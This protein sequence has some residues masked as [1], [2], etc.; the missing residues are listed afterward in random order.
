MSNKK[1][2]SIGWPPISRQPLFNGKTKNIGRLTNQFCHS[3]FFSL[4]GTHLL[5]RFA[6]HRHDL[7]AH[8]MGPLAMLRGGG[9][10]HNRK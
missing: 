3:N 5:A 7:S 6:S 8:G 9:G 10:E 1:T 4:V 2:I